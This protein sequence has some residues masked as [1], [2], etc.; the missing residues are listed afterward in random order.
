MN[1]KVARKAT[2]LYFAWAKK[3]RKKK[4]LVRFFGGEPLMNFTVVKDVVAYA[5]KRAK[6]EKMEVE[7]D[8]TTNGMLIDDA[9]MDFFKKTPEMRVIIS[10]DGDARTQ[11]AN[12]KMKDLKTDSYKNILTYK[13]RLIVLP[14][15]TVNMVIA[16]NQV[17][18]FYE[19]FLYNYHLGFRRFN[20]LPAYFTAWGKNELELLASG[21]KKIIG[22]LRAH[23]DVSVKNEEIV[24]AIPFFNSGFVVDCNGDLFDTNLTLSHHYAHVQGDLV[25]GNVIKDEI[26]GL[27][28]PAHT[29]DIAFLRR[30]AADQKLF[31]ASLKVDAILSNFVRKLSA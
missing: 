18:N 19:N 31:Y 29:I 28:S 3:N 13:D 12:R 20:F 9:V 25:K 24:S 8:L 27:P 16:P 17:R 7:F 14:N 22:F 23:K 15:V 11:N 5:K 2:F 21:F 26:A 6:R 1:E 10:L 30:N 4:L